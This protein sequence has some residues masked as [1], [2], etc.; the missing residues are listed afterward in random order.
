M[1]KLKI[2][3]LGT[4]NT[5]KGLCSLLRQES[6]LII[7]KVFTQ[8][9]ISK[10]TDFPYP[11]LLTNDIQE[12]RNSS[13]V[14]LDCSNKICVAFN[15]I[16]TLMSDKKPVFTTNN[17]FQLLFGKYLNT[18]GQISLCGG[19][20]TYSLYNLFWDAMGRGF[21]PMLLLNHGPFLGGSSGIEIQKKIENCLLA[22]IFDISALNHPI[23]S[24][25][26]A[27]IMA[28]NTEIPL[29][30]TI[31]NNSIKSEVSILSKHSDR[32]Q[33]QHLKDL[34][35]GDGPVYTLENK[36]ILNHMEIPFSIMDIVENNNLSLIPQTNKNMVYAICKKRIDKGTFIDCGLESEYLN[37]NILDNK[38]DLIPIS[39]IE[40]VVIKNDIQAGEY[41]TFDDVLFGNKNFVDISKKAINQITDVADSIDRRYLTS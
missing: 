33:V 14:Y 23:I 18:I 13:D 39:L 28:R 16:K 30:A 32:E 12:L 20:A 38:K 25:V 27:E 24:D 37:G 22:N 34:G 31:M 40:Y 10:R 35:Y 5:C 15:I 36:N 1:T 17:S 9:D 11:E 8:T 3:I 2:G 41:I 29:C 7:S 26:V 4:G 6:N 19:S 21:L